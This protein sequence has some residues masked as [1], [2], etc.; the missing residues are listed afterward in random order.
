MAKR[1]VASGS[2]FAPTIFITTVKDSRS[3]PV[4][5]R[6]NTIHLTDG[7]ETLF[8]RAYN[9][10]GIVAY[11]KKTSAVR[12]RTRIADEMNAWRLGGS[13]TDQGSRTTAPRCQLVAVGSIGVFDAS[14]TRRG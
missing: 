6:W 7:S 13:R 2:S 8:M 12:R 5:L 10:D 11:K 3:E 9:F 1:T 4:C 14:L